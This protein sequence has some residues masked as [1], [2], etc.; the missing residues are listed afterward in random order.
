MNKQPY[1]I[2]ADNQEMTDLL[3]RIRAVLDEYLNRGSV[4]DNDLPSP[5]SLIEDIT[6]LL[7]EGNK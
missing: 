1:E 5:M 7:E 2:M 4:W 6:N 3:V